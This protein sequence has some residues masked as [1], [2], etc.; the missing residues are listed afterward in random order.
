MIQFNLLPDVKV[1][2]IK[3]K[4]SKRTIMVAAILSV[5]VSLSLLAIMVSVTMYQKFHIN[6]LSSD[7][8]KVQKDLE[9]TQNLAKILTVQNQLKSL[10]DLY[11][12]RPET[13]RVFGYVEQTTPAQIQIS[14]MTLDFNA[15][16][17][18]VSGISDTL[19][20]VNRYVDTLK[21]TNY[22]VAGVEGKE[23][24]FTNVVLTAFS[25]SKDSA[26][27]SVSME[28]NPDIFDRA[29][30]VALEVPKTITTRSETELPG[31]DLFNAKETN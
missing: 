29:K 26:S 7:I 31:N 18:N 20:S 9:N 4:K 2:Y 3:A 1:E 23:K 25:R 19:E 10:P 16:S 17:I 30:E 15:N 27:Y 11:S 13:S 12:K 22:R 14:N 24:A 28:F 6:S 21:F 8:T 5:I